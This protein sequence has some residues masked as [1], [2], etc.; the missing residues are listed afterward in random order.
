MAQKPKTQNES[1]PCY[2]ATLLVIKIIRF[3]IVL[4]HLSRMLGYE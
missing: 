2:A 3:V 4:L 1:S